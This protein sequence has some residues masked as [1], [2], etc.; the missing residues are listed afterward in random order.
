MSLGECHYKNTSSVL[1]WSIIVFSM[2]VDGV[3]YRRH[4]LILN[5]TIQI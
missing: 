3:L 2:D 5:E 4:D 1:T